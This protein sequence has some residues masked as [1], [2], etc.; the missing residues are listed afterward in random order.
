MK[1]IFALLLLIVFSLVSFSAEKPKLFP[2]V[3]SIVSKAESEVSK[4]RTA[5]DAANDKAFTDAEKA[6]KAELDKLMK[7][8]K[9]DDAVATK[10]IIEG[11]RKNVVVK[12]DEAAGGDPLG[13]VG[14]YFS[15]KKWM[16]DYLKGKWWNWNNSGIVGFK[17]G[18]VMDAPNGG[19]WEFDKGHLVVVM[20]ASH[21]LTPKI[22]NG[23][24][25]GFDGAIGTNGN[26]FTVVPSDPPKSPLNQSDVI[27]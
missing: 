11:L 18:G 7:A 25:T 1:T 23:E 4:N 19:T 5:Y 13:N 12:V 10:K 17:S 16:T 27:K 3:Q 14:N 8:G 26:S 6:L 9:L 2:S 20:G 15:N 21:I 22:V 24:I